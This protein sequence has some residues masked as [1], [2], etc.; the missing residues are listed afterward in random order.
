M[1]LS[2]T[3]D[4][5]ELIRRIA[6]RDEQAFEILFGRLMPSVFK[7]SYAMLLNRQLA[8]DAAQESFI[9]LWN[10]AEG[11]RPEASVKTWLMAI[12][13]NVCL[14]MIRK[15]RND[16]KKY[17][18]LYREHLSSPQATIEGGEQ[19]LLRKDREQHMK[20]AL[21]L[22]PERQREAV[23]LV[24]YVGIQNIEAAR[25]MGLNVRAFDSLLARA[26]R[27]LRDNLS[28]EGEKKG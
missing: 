5:Y 2:E 18:D 21:F 12:T 7:L 19:A 28:E 26:R 15:K 22:L 13:R 10:H 8:E 17:Q 16:I 14:D 24:Y 25:I 1:K 20:T 6:A 11:W 4:D 9:R 3:A 27:S 23:T